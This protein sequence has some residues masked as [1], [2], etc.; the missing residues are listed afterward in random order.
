M[1]HTARIVVVSDPGEPI[2]EDYEVEF[3]CFSFGDSGTFTVRH[4]VCEGVSLCVELTSRTDPNV[5]TRAAF[6]LGLDDEDLDGL[7]EALQE[8]KRRLET[9]G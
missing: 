2:Q 5:T 7:I 3:D 4:N 1:S 9:P 6:S 8:A